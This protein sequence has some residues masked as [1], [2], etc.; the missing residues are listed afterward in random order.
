MI[1]WIALMLT[2]LMLCAPPAATAAESGAQ[3]GPDSRTKRET[4]QRV[5]VGST[6]VLTGNFMNDI[7]GGNN[8]SDLEARAILHALSPVDWHNGVGAYLAD[9]AVV[10]GIVSALDESGNKRYVIALD[11][12]LRYS[13]GT[14]ITARDYVFAILLSASKELRAIGGTNRRAEALVG[15][16]AYAKGLSEVISGVRLY[17]DLQFAVTISKEYMPDYYDL[18]LINVTPYPISVIAPGCVVRDDGEGAYIANANGGADTLFT[19]ELL[20]KTL[21]DPQTGYVTHPS[22]SSGPYRFVDYDDTAHVLRLEINPYFKGNA[23]AILPSVAEITF[24]PVEPKTMIG[25]LGE[26]TVDLVVKCTE[27]QVI[28]EG[29][30]QTTSGQV[31]AKNAMR[32]G[33]GLISF[34]CEKQA[35]SSDQVRKALCMSLDRD[36]L[37]KRLAGG[38]G[39][40]VDGY[41][42]LG[43]WMYQVVSGILEPPDSAESSETQKSQV[44]RWNELRLTKSP[45]YTYD[46]AG[47]ERLLIG[48]GWTLDAA[49]AA[50]AGGIRHKRVGEA[51]V[52]LDLSVAV[53]TGSAAAAI[54]ETWQADLEAIGV[55]LTIQSVDFADLMDMYY[56]ETPRDCEMIFIGTDFSS[57]F[58]PTS[59]YAIDEN[60]VNPCGLSDDTL[61]RLALDM[62]QTEPGDAYTYCRKWIA[63]Q[64]AWSDQMPAIPLYSNVYYDFHTSRLLDYDIDA[65]AAWTQALYYARLSEAMHVE[66]DGTTTYPEP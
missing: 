43:Q 18:S 56:R 48:D 13:D 29:F 50:Y 41:Y 65:G 24:R 33:L 4:F 23:D 31:V 60:A 17:G 15:A 39:L 66:T 36:S 49:G 21:L 2:V 14:P 63:F 19:A 64:N 7:M 8:A 6:T 20:E 25:E 37:V 9:P 30:A 22:V 11:S 55:K 59:A 12:D 52:A 54:L 53:P 45:Q 16:D 10:S 47:A 51:L 38:Y 26:G 35:V 57:V 46:L 34:N 1:R 27:E 32:N 40:R 62:R 28:K 3:T 58:D 61:Y 44:G 5:I 42:G